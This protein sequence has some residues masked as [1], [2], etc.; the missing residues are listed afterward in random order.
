ML[1]D[2]VLSDEAIRIWVEAGGIAPPVEFDV[3]GWQVS[4]L[5]GAVLDLAAEA[6]TQSIWRAAR[7][8]LGFAL[9]PA[10][11]DAFAA[12]MDDGFRALLA[13]ERTPERFAAAL[14]LAW[15]AE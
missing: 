10:A 14:Q 11:P 7:A 15:E 4:P 2:F 9:G 6:R 8:D 3:G 5:R 13:G 12:A 1:L